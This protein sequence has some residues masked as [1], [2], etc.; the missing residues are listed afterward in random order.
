MGEARKIK[1]KKKDVYIFM[2]RERERENNMWVMMAKY[3]HLMTND[4]FP[5]A[6]GFF[7]T[8]NIIYIL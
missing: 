7:F 4:S 8:T 1:E 2:Y 6:F 3:Q 5:M